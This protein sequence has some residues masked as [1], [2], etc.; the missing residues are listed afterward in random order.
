MPRL[1]D[2]TRQRRREH[3]AAAAMRCFARN[4]FASTSMA[5][6]IVEAGSSAGSVYANFANKADLVRYTAS[7]ALRALDAAVG[8]DL[9]SER[10]PASVLGHLLRTS[11][12]R[13]RAQ[14]LLQIWAEVP[15]DEELADIGRRSLGELR[16]SVRA[17]LPAPA[18]DDLTDVMLAVVHGFLV[19]I[20]VDRDV[21]PEPLAARAVAVF[22]SATMTP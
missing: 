14:I 19:R 7:D 13:T 8:A 5:D 6:I 21:D 9:P 11:G 17:A 22:E 4:G 16:E 10:T 2:A 1:T 15:R 3:I 20:A 12:D 18:A